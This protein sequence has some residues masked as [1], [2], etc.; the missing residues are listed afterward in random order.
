MNTPSNRDPQVVPAR[1]RMIRAIGCLAY[2]VGLGIVL[3]IAAFI[4][5]IV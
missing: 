3:A 5:S 1:S 4:R 2:P